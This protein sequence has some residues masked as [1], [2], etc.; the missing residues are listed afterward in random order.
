[1]FEKSTFKRATSSES[2]NQ[3]IKEET[4]STGFGLGEAGRSN[5]RF[6]PLNDIQ[7]GNSDHGEAIKTNAK[8]KNWIESLRE[9]L[10]PCLTMDNPETKTLKKIIKNDYGEIA[11]NEYTKRKKEIVDL[12]D[13]FEKY[14]AN[15]QITEASLPKLLKFTKE[16]K[17]IS[18][19]IADKHKTFLGE[20]LPYYVLLHHE[21]EGIKDVIYMRA[22][23]KYKEFIDEKGKLMEQ[24]NSRIE[25]LSEIKATLDQSYSGR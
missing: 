2:H 10:I 7:N 17:D 23:D 8:G 3:E 1:M 12:E 19:K 13:A 18:K 22:K 24:Y 4:T 14:R 9:K 11:H 21:D 20:F 16:L 15:E 25:K 6:F 5:T